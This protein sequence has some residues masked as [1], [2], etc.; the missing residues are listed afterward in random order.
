MLVQLLVLRLVLPG[1]KPLQLEILYG[2]HHSITSV[3]TYIN[4]DWKI[5]LDY[6]VPV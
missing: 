3:I 6:E 4:N 5:A 1:M 2:N